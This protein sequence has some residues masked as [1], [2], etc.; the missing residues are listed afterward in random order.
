MLEI[1]L[2]VFRPSFS[3]KIRKICKVVEPPRLKSS[4]LPRAHR[5][6]AVSTALSV[7]HPAQVQ[8]ALYFPKRNS[9]FMPCVR[10]QLSLQRNWGHP[11]WAFKSQYQFKGECHTSIKREVPRPKPICHQESKCT[12]NTWAALTLFPGRRSHIDITAK[13]V[14]EEIK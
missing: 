7:F 1:D 12:E 14:C 11:R 6:H 9:I 4:F 2:G 8:K 13:W 10:T 3:F 5:S